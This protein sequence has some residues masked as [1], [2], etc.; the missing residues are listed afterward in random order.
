MDWKAE[1]RNRFVNLEWKDEQDKKRHLRA[2]KASSVQLDNV[3]LMFVGVGG[4]GIDAVL[5]LKD[6]ME[7]LYNPEEAGRVEYLLIDTDKIGT[8]RGINP[9]DT[10]VIQSSD[11][12]MLLREAQRSTGG[13]HFI[14]DEIRDWLDD[15]LSPFRV[16]NG[17]AGIR[18]AGRLILFLNFQRIYDALQRKLSKISENYDAS[19]CR[20]RI[21]LF[22]GIGGGT[23]SGMFID[24]S[25]M[26]RSIQN[27]DLQ[28]VIFMPDVSCL[29]P[30]LRET[31]KKNIQRNGFA[32]LK[33][34]DYLMILDRVGESFRQDYPGGI[35][36]D[37]ND[38]VFDLC[39]L[40]GAQEDGRTPI[41]S[42]Q[43]IFEKT[44]E[45]IL[46]EIQEKIF[47]FGMSSYKSNLANYQPTEPFCERYAAI[48]AAAAY[49]PIDYYYGW[50]LE[51]VF[52][53]FGL[54]SG[55]DTGENYRAGLRDE[56]WE[57]VRDEIKEVPYKRWRCYKHAQDH[58]GQNMAAKL[59][60][61][62]LIP[63][64]FYLLREE[65]YNKAGEKISKVIDETKLGGIK[66]NTIAQKLL[67]RKRALRNRYEEAYKGCFG[68]W[69]TANETQLKESYMIL[70]KIVER[71]REYS[72]AK[73]TDLPKTALFGAEEFR[74]IQ[75]E[76]RYKQKI[77]E[78]AKK[79]A[80]DLCQNPSRWNGLMSGRPK[81]LS[82]YVGKLL[83]G[84]FANSG[85]LDLE[86]LIK[87]AAINGRNGQEEFLGEHLSGLNARQ[88]W[89]RSPYYP[90]RDDYHR[91]LA[92]P[93]G[94][95]VREWIEN[96]IATDGE[97][98]VFC[99]NPITWR[100][101]RAILVPGNSLY[102]FDG[103]S[104]MEMCYINASNRAGLHLYAREGKDWNELPSPYFET[105]W[106]SGDAAKRGE[107]KKRNDHYREVFDEALDLGIIV[108]GGNGYYYI[109][110]GNT[111]VTIG[112]IVDDA[113]DREISKNMFIHMFE[114]RQWVEREVEKRKKT[115]P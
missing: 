23:G 39:T 20:P 107:E 70:E 24:L 45:Y 100:L 56:I 8:G 79:L 55:T 25:Y 63:A 34:L 14:S 50:W 87:Y 80:E 53:A 109:V 111:R 4:T 12:A 104:K 113:G 10:I 19:K 65:Y 101:A 98:D 108:Y 51:D 16:M 9:A 94:S 83:W 36:V 92:G 1:Y 62:K 15:S 114:H 27:V 75:Q 28:G 86:R 61:G 54:G 52:K 26:M 90:P 64:H 112:D 73:T 29:K 47:E 40:V 81:W 84:F 7:T 95:P 22:A 42:E 78:A 33:E 5:A 41:G 105:K 85:C 11:T 115:S 88:L 57:D 89:P 69:I 102:T 97:G 67:L 3:P 96:W 49:I 21:Y 44:A 99:V 43:K 72:A 30:N 32:A 37:R 38:P 60:N 31:H 91:V 48:G 68:Q 6:K 66:R 2:Y 103:I 59:A 82:D 76:D 77:T 93:E 106:V 46:F 35:G 13:K 110:Y 58:M 74:Q 17:A 71:M 18:Q